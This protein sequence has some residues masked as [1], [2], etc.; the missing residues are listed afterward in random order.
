MKNSVALASRVQLAIKAKGNIDLLV[1]NIVLRLS[2][3]FYFLGP[4]M[5]LISTTKLWYNSI[6]IYF[7]PVSLRNSF[8]IEKSLLIQII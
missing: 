3:A 8:L 2:D 7:F 5:N 1:R 6:G 4:V